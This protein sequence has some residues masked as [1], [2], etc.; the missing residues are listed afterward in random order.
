[1]PTEELAREAE[2]IDPKLRDLVLKAAPLRRTEGLTVLLAICAAALA[3]CKA[4]INVNL[5]VNELVRDMTTHSQGLDD[6]NQP[7]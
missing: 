7:K 4:N 5:D 1:M 6:T 2:R 3:Q